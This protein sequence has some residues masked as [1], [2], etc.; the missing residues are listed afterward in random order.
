VAEQSA[1]VRPRIVAMTANALSGDRE[2][3]LAAGMDDYIAKPILPVDVQSIIERMSS[4]AGPLPETHEHEA[5]PLIDQR[6]VTELGALDEPGTPSL[7]RSVMRDYL[8]EAPGIIS[9]IKRLADQREATQLSARAHKL[10]GVSA[11]IG[12]AG[13][14]DVCKRIEQQVSAGDLTGLSAMVDQLELRFARTRSELQT[15]V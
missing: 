12:A 5:A 8:D 13:M 14:A 7:L 2:R 6:I 10:G 15:L 1:L 9:D 3:C 11:S 4:V